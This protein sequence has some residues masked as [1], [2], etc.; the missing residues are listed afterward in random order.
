[1][2]KSNRGKWYKDVGALALIYKLKDKP[3]INVLEELGLVR[4]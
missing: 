1:M 4:T 3:N 2:I